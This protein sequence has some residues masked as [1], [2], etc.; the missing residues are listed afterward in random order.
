[1]SDHTPVHLLMLPDEVSLGYRTF[2]VELMGKPVP[3][4]APH[5]MYDPYGPTMINPNFGEEETVNAFMHEML[6]CIL[7]MYGTHLDLSQNGLEETVCTILG[8]GLTEL[9]KRNPK[10]VYFIW[11]S[12]HGGEEPDES[13]DSE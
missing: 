11:E 4:E 13:E 6:H 12:L 8:N 5:G 7:H 2:D 3:H 10:A 1:M 9:F